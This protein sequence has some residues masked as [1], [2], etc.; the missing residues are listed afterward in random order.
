MKLTGKIIHGQGRGHHLGL[1]TINLDQHPSNL[2]TGVYAVWVSLKSGRYKGAMNWGPRPTFNET[3]HVMEV[4]LIEFE[5]EL[6]GEKV[7]LEIV[8]K[9]RDVEK[10]DSKDLLKAQIKKDIADVSALLL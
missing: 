1:P 3:E 2:E 4:H 8:Q 10:F 6:Y 5:G 9:L 7:E